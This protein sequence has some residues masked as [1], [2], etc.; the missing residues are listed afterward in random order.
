MGSVAVAIVPPA[1]GLEE[2]RTGQAHSDRSSQLGHNVY[3]S[4]SAASKAITAKG[5]AYATLPIHPWAALANLGNIRLQASNTTAPPPK[6]ANDHLLIP[7]WLQPHSAANPAAASRAS[8]AQRAAAGQR[9]TLHHPTATARPM[10][11]SR[12]VA[13]SLYDSVV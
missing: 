13:R 8:A 3:P 12:V 11:G 7:S 5:R 6:I 4:A 9:A 2:A 1:P 10:V